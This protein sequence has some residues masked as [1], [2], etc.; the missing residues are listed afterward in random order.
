MLQE[1]FLQAHCEPLA[2]DVE[3]RHLALFSLESFLRCNISLLGNNQ[4]CLA[5]N[6]SFC[7]AA[8]SK[9]EWPGIPKLLLGSF[10]ILLQNLRAIPRA[11]PCRSKHRLQTLKM[12]KLLLAPRFG[13]N[14]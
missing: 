8:N 13:A 2:F 7:N 11:R 10:D 3:R 1:L 9:C 12:A 4:P 5:A 6:Q 14:L